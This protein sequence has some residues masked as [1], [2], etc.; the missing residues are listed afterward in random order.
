MYRICLM[1]LRTL[2]KT[3]LILVNSKKIFSIFS[4]NYNLKENHIFER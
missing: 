4:V 3:I 1:V 2:N